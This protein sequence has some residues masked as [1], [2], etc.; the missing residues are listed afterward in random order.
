MSTKREAKIALT[1]AWDEYRSDILS[2]IARALSERLPKQW[3]AVTSVLPQGMPTRSWRSLWKNA[4]EIGLRTTEYIPVEG[5]YLLRHKFGNA[6]FLWCV[7]RADSF[8]CELDTLVDRARSKTPKASIPG[9][10]ELQDVIDFECRGYVDELNKAR[11]LIETAEKSPSPRKRP[12][13]PIQEVPDRA[14]TKKIKAY[15]TTKHEPLKKRQRVSDMKREVAVLKPIVS[16][17]N[18][19]QAEFPTRCGYHRANEIM[20]THKTQKIKL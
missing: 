12:L 6:Y 11:N 3:V 8:S 16:P 18:S 7:S 10:T 20:A 19:L 4:M 5:Y 9:I 17:S 14:L 2:S 15:S 1:L 13:A